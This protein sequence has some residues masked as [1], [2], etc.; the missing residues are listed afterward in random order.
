[1]KINIINGSTN[2][3]ELNNKE[4]KLLII[5]VIVI[6]ILQ[7]YMVR[8]INIFIYIYKKMFSKVN[9]FIILKKL[10]KIF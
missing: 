10:I 5:L 6:I 7:F 2:N 9:K 8:F 3:L 1:M 4:M